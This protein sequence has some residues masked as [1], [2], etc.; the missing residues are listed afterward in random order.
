MLAGMI[1]TLTPAEM[2]LDELRAALTPLLPQ[3]AAFDGWTDAALASAGRALGVPEDRARL[4]FPGGAV[5]MIDAW[6]A[7]IDLE[8][9]A[10]LPADRIA[11]MKIRDR[12]RA[13]V[14]A[15]LE[16]AAP[17]REALRGALTILALPRNAA[18]GVR[19]GWRAAD[20][21]W[22]LAGDTATDLNH[23][24]KRVTLAALYGATLL[25]WM[26]DDS[27]DWAE[28]RA[29][30]DRRIDGVMRFEKLKARFRSDPERRFSP[31]RLLGRL[32]YPAV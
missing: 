13:M 22:R 32:R 7:M 5:E 14:L 21:M 31:V 19:L 28:T 16:A 30:L 26:D 25:A 11:A 1:H 15:R 17:H 12:I 24:T 27:E 9:I 29:F 10:A 23:Y 6:F 8:M 2:T 18:A 20:R 3:E 4:A